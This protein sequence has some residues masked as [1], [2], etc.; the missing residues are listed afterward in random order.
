M[1]VLLLTR[2]LMLLAMVQIVSMKH[3]LI[4]INQQ[5]VETSNSYRNLNLGSARTR[6]E[7]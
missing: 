5:N 1:R 4:E 2:I 6:N 7:I 3:L